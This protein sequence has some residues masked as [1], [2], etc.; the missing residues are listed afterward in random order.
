MSFHDY[1][2]IKGYQETPPENVD[3]A[4][5]EIFQGLGAE[6]IAQQTVNTETGLVPV[7]PATP[8]PEALWTGQN[9]LIQAESVYAGQI[10]KLFKQQQAKMPADSDSLINEI[11]AELWEPIEEFLSDFFGGFVTGV[12]GAA[13]TPLQAPVFT[14]SKFVFEVGISYAYSKIKA[15]FQK[16]VDICLGIIEENAAMLQ[17]DQSRENYELRRTNLSLH[18]EMLENVLA[19]INAMEAMLDRTLVK[20]TDTKGIVKALKP[21]AGIKAAVE[22]LTFVDATLKYADNTSF[23][24]GGK[25]LHH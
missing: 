22:D 2:K 18:T 9:T 12:T 13:G 1:I 11:L 24:V 14:I 23:H 4:T 17:L 3:P 8:I 10:E 20:G 25:V 16:G 6:L 19:Q 15:L 21:M 5:F 7:A